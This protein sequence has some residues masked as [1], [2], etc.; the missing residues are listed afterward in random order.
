MQEDLTSKEWEAK[1]YPSYIW[2]HMPLQ[3]VITSHYQGLKCDTSLGTTNIRGEVQGPRYVNADIQ[4]IF[5]L[6]HL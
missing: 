2:G 4:K 5:I 6:I 3:N 1:L